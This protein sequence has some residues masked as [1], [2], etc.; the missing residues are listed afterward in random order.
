MRVKIK[1]RGSFKNTL[2]YFNSGKQL[3]SKLREICKEFGEEAINALREATPKDSGETSSRWQYHIE[4][5]G[6][7]ITNDAQ[8]NGILIAL[9][10]QYGHGTKSG[11]YVQG[12][13][14]IN[15]ALEPVFDKILNKWE[16]E[17]KNL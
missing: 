16:K 10:L 5:W 12:N 9:L 17:V 11:S 14:Y 1:V 7:V 6:L 3:P 8:N 15:Q 2:Q 13:D 4:N